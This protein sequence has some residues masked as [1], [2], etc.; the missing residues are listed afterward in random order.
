[1]ADVIIIGIIIVAVY[2]AV[3]GQI[4]YNLNRSVIVWCG[5]C[6]LLPTIGCLILAYVASKQVADCPRC[7]MDVQRRRTAA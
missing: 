7:R 4:A 6:F 2:L 1:M 3:V 5:L